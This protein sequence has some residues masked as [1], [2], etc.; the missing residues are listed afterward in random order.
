ISR[1]HEAGDLPPALD[2][3]AIPASKPAQQHPCPGNGAV[4]GDDLAPW[5]HV[6]RARDQ[7]SRSGK[8]RRGQGTKVR[9]PPAEYVVRRRSV[10]GGH[11]DSPATK[12]QNSSI[13]SAKRATMVAQSAAITCTRESTSLSG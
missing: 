8:R 12:R 10:G 6:P 7:R 3:I 13:S 5:T 11:A 2:I 9:Q 1:Q 4:C